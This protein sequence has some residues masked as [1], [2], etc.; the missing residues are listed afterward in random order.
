LARTL[1]FWSKGLTMFERAMDRA[2]KLMA[3]LGSRLLE[4]QKRV[5]ESAEALSLRQPAKAALWRI[6]PGASAKV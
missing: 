5:S 2:E 4:T 1:D 3:I 6:F